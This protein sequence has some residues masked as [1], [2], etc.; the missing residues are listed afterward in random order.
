MADQPK[1]Y[2]GGTGR[3]VSV[4]AL[5]DNQTVIRRLN[6]AMAKAREIADTQVQVINNPGIFAWLDDDLFDHIYVSQVS[7]PD[8]SVTL[9]KQTDIPPRMAANRKDATWY[10]LA[11]NVEN[12][13][14]GQ[15]LESPVIIKAQ[16]TG[17]WS[18]LS[19]TERDRLNQ[20]FTRFLRF[21]RLPVY[22]RVA[23][24][25]GSTQQLMS[26][27]DEFA[28]DQN[29]W[30]PLGDS[31][32]YHPASSSP[33][34]V[35][36]ANK[37]MRK[38]TEG[39]NHFITHYPAHIGD[40]DN[41]I[42]V[43]GDGPY[44]E[45]RYNVI[46][47][48]VDGGIDVDGNVLTARGNTTDGGGDI[49]WSKARE[50]HLAQTGN[51]MPDN[52]G[53]MQI[54][55]EGRPYW[56]GQKHVGGVWKM[57]ATVMPDQEYNAM[58]RRDGM[59]P[60]S[61]DMR[62]SSDGLAKQVANNR[63]V[64]GRTIWHLAKDKVIKPT[65]VGGLL[66]IPSAMR[67]F[68]FDQFL[69]WHF[70][71]VVQDAFNAPGEFQDKMPDL[72][73][74]IQEILDDVGP[75][76][77]ALLSTFE[78]PDVADIKRAEANRQVDRF[79]QNREAMMTG[80]PYASVG[81]MDLTQRMGL[82][83]G[84]MDRSSKGAGAIMIPMF[85]G[86]R[87][88]AADLP[89]WVEPAERGMVRLLSRRSRKGY[90]NMFVFNREDMVD[91]RM[92]VAFGGPDNDD[93]FGAKLARDLDNPDRLYAHVT[94]D[95][96]SIGGGAWMEVHPDDAAFLSRH[97]GV[98]FDALPNVREVSRIHPDMTSIKGVPATGVPKRDD[99]GHCR[100]GHL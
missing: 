43:H 81:V 36:K 51:P 23:N 12:P 29:S 63:M 53:M 61:L 44:T 32:M 37:R 80:S 91:P 55:W 54:N 10:R 6:L 14:T 46:D 31:G 24:A 17:K 45:V 70:D 60:A 8:G 20:Q 2:T 71:H 99:P 40:R 52:M 7:S 50:I 38:L 66:S 90:V 56:D 100:D 75:D 3:E 79:A 69:D 39:G 89:G 93:E 62:I 48:F 59:D 67:F 4:G 83:L 85:K 94:R 21:L 26:A 49:R 68:D 97:G 30:N 72:N 77:E 58:L 64:S 34:F 9:S 87:T 1:W 28:P 41:V 95:P 47:N 86:K 19:N 42:P 15:P 27:L 65:P 35:G 82:K 13:M 76:N 74:R 88:D 33:D 16:T 96:Q 92:Q 5:D 78:D 22:G 57:M 18:R 25:M 73:E 84:G 11:Q 98:V